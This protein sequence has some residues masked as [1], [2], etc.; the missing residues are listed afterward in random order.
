ME[1]ASRRAQRDAE[2]RQ[3]QLAKESA[4]RAKTQAQQQAAF[5]VDRFENQVERLTSVH[6]E[7]PE[8][9][10]WSSI[11]NLPAPDPPERS[12][13]YEAAA[14]A[15]LNA[16]SPSLL[17]RLLF[18]AETKR[19]ELVTAVESARAQDEQAYQKV[20]QAYCQR[21]AD[22][23]GR[24]E[25]AWRILQQDPQAYG[26]ALGDFDPFAD[27]EE[28][29]V[30]INYELHGPHLIEARLTVAESVLP[31]EVKSLT[32]TGR[33]SAK[34][35]PK[36]QHYEIYRNFVCGAALRA[37]RELF[38]FLPVETVLVNVQANLLNTRTGHYGLETIVS[39]AFARKTFGELNFDRLDPFDA[40]ENFS[41]RM[42]FKKTA[43]FEPVSPL[44]KAEVEGQE[45]GATSL[46]PGAWVD[47][48]TADKPAADALAQILSKYVEE[49]FGHWLPVREVAQ[50]AG[51]SEETKLTLPVSRRIAEAVEDAG[52]CIEPDPRF[53]VGGYEWNQRVGIFRPAAGES[54][55]PA[56]AYQGA[57]NL[58]RLCVI[59]AA[60]DGSVD[61]AELAIF[62]Q[63]IQHQLQF[64]QTELKR[65]AVLERL[66]SVYPEAGNTT[67]AKV[68]KGIPLEKRM[69]VGQV[70]VKVAAVDHVITKTEYRALERVFKAFEL[71]AQ[72]LADLI[73]QVCPAPPEETIQR[74]QS[75]LPGEPIPP[76]R[77]PLGFT[78]D[79]SKVYA[80]TNETKEVI[81]ILSEVMEEEPAALVP[82]P[83]T[84][85]S[86]S[87][88]LPST[89]KPAG[90][91]S[92][93]TSG[94]FEGLDPAL[95]P[96][97]ERLLARAAW[98]RTDFQALASEF[99][100][101]PL[102]LHDV[103]NEWADESLGDFLLEG[104]D[105]VVIRHEL[106]TKE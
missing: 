22:W 12:A 62:R 2:R 83:A 18:R 53:G 11:Y 7:S 89:M 6:K 49:E 39:A 25:L 67:L 33:L 24:R 40:M 64:G 92:D 20:Y 31:E 66:L 4:Q 15:R 69:F 59:V 27:L 84:Q 78:L 8:T 68:A 44:S 9:W 91:T 29:G 106:L 76:P 99:H 61:Q 46:A 87:P 98:P 28:L 5:E 90:E 23:T 42:E 101:M 1:A 72:N 94:K 10:D 54:I 32:G 74:A 102:S 77:K 19:Q 21:H 17:D 79:M 60:S 96:V 45:M 14:A 30:K 48:E 104:E 86:A 47:V 80:I 75:G 13:V 26:D 88:A 43:G 103:I 55:A 51:L 71:P 65:L 73:Q 57:A 41:C 85:S 70:L 37:G 63:L 3:R 58:L 34:A 100:L 16:F 35:M 50:F 97:L 56:T 36:G 105:P 81:G 93:S 82:P 38:A 95:H 52:Y